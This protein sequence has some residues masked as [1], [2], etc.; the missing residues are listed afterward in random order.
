LPERIGR[1]LRG[2]ENG[3]KEGKKIINRSGRALAIS[4]PPFC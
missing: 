4:Q 2:E 1:Q 3:Q